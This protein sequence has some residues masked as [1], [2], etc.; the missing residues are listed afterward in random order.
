[1]PFTLIRPARSGPHPVAV[2]SPAILG[3]SR[4]IPAGSRP[5]ASPL[6][7]IP[8]EFA[9][10]RTRCTQFLANAPSC[11]RIWLSSASAVFSWASATFKRAFL[12][13][14]RAFA[15]RS[16]RLTLWSFSLLSNCRRSISFPCCQDILALRIE[17]AL[18]PINLFVLLKGP[19]VLRI[20]HRAQSTNLFVLLQRVL[21]LAIDDRLQTLNLRPSLQDN[22]SLLLIVWATRSSIRRVASSLSI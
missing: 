1:M 5:R 8:R 6:H 7:A 9:Q 12:A 10:F 19:L 16:R 18:Q 13:A 3:A 21:G 22:S 14:T 11:V 17:E 15:S 20:E 4:P 2:V